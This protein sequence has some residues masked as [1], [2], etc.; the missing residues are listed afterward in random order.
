LRVARHI[1]GGAFAISGPVALFFVPRRPGGCIARFSRVCPCLP[2]K[3]GGQTS[4]VP[5]S[6][7]LRAGYIY[8]NMPAFYAICEAQ[9]NGQGP[10]VNVTNAEPNQPVQLLSYGYDRP[11]AVGATSRGNST[12]GTGA[13]GNVTVTN[14]GEIDATFTALAGISEGFGGGAGGSVVGTN[15]GTINVLP[16][17][18]SSFSGNPASLAVLQSA[19]GDGLY[20]ASIGGIGTTGVSNTGGHYVVGGSGGSGGIAGSVR[21]INSATRLSANGD[22]T[23]SGVPISSIHIETDMG[24]GISA[25]SVNARVS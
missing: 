5:A 25:M 17:E 24:D 14:K 8:P 16:L 10:D 18:G 9:G 11:A 3:S 7:E 2:V 15:S 13:G 23:A 20:L 19:Q 21:G 22:L 4:T 6:F 12:A 1:F